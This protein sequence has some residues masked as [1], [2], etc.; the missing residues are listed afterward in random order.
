MNYTEE[1][2]NELEALEAIYSNE[3]NGNYVVI[4]LNESLIKLNLLLFSHI[5]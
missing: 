5:S 3:L 2:N 4:H 1:Q